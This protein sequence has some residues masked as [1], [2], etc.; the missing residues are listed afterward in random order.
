MSEMLQTERDYVRSLQFVIEN[1]LPELLRDDVPQALR[2]KRNVIFGN[3]EQIHAF[4]SRYFLRALER[5]ENNPVHVARV[6]LEHVRIE[7]FL[8]E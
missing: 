2:G 4:H 3:V 7:Y 8:E 5:C 1:Y 6:F